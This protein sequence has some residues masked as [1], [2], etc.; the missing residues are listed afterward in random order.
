MIFTRQTIVVEPDVLVVEP[1][2]QV[3]DP[4]VH[5][6]H[7]LAIVELPTAFGKMQLEF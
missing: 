2:I 3:V 7:L 4:T 1:D 6:L 5:Q